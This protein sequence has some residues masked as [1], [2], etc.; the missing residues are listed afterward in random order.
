MRRLTILL[1]GLL[2]LAG[3]VT[4]QRLPPPIPSAASPTFTASSRVGGGLWRQGRPFGDSRDY[5]W[6]GVLV[7]GV[8]LGLAGGIGAAVWC[9]REGTSHNCVAATVL[10]AAFF[11]TIGSVV[12]GLI[13]SSISKGQPSGG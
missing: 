5:R 12:G 10:S 8:G 6:E 9:S 11:G 1:F 7:G 4:G 2:L 3:P 13:G